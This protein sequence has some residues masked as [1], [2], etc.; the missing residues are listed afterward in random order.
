MGNLEGVPWQRRHFVL[1]QTPL[2]VLLLRLLGSDAGRVAIARRVVAQEPGQRPAWRELALEAL[3]GRNYERALTLVARAG[4]PRFEE[5]R[6]LQLRVYAL[7]ALGRYDEARK[8][9]A[10]APKG[11]PPRFGNWLEATFDFGGGPARTR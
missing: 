3:A 9:L 6:L 1:T 8:V 5:L 4:E 2:T 11:L 7:S 10:A